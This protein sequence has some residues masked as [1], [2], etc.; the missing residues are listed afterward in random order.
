MAVRLVNGQFVYDT[1]GGGSTSPYGGRLSSPGTTGG[2]TGGVSIGVSGAPGSGGST[3]SRINDYM[4]QV[5]ESIAE[6]NKKALEQQKRV[7]ELYRGMYQNYSPYLQTASQLLSQQPQDLSSRLYGNLAEQIKGAYDP[8]AYAQQVGSQL[9]FAGARSGDAIRGAYDYAERNLRQPLAQMAGQVATSEAQRQQQ[10]RLANIQAASGL[11]DQGAGYRRQWAD[12]EN[13]INYMPGGYVPGMGELLAGSGGGGYA[14][15]FA[16]S[17]NM[18]SSAPQESS[19]QPGAGY[20]QPSGPV[21]SPIYGGGGG[22]PELG[23]THVSYGLPRGSGTQQIAGASG[24]LPGQ[25]TTKNLVGKKSKGMSEQ[26]RKRFARRHLS[27][28]VTFA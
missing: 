23:V 14:P 25:G 1:S 20:F 16:A 27:P 17:T 13:D 9:G 2:G 7:R 18:S 8:N 11:Y 5:E 6:A 19:M 10:E 3:R 15:P 24:V 28:F 12:W 26:D 22:R 21:A 4:K